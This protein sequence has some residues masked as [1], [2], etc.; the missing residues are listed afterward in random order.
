VRIVWRGRATTELAVAI[1]VYTVA[2][3][4]R[5]AEMETRVLDLA[6]AGVDDET[7]AATLTTEGF[8]SARLNKVMARAVKV[9]R[10]RH[11]VLQAP[12]LS[13]PRR[14]PGW[15]T[16]SQLARQIEVSPHWLHRRIRNRTIDMSRDPITGR[17]L[18][19]D[20]E[21]TIARLRSLN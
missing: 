9:I 14:I 7:I 21:I 6:R 8:R 2:A 15:L 17:Y 16:V 12:W 4:T 20:T 3:L 5:G 10:L 18:F 19:P 1:A 13:Q 11:K